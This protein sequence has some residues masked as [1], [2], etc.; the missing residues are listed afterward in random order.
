MKA[1]RPGDFVQP[2]IGLGEPWKEAAATHNHRETPPEGCQGVSFIPVSFSR[3]CGIVTPKQGEAAGQ[4]QAFCRTVTL[5][6]LAL[7]VLVLP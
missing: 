7:S 2:G 3:D 4:Q 6:Q 5:P 1:P